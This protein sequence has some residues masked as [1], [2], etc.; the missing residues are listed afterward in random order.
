MRGVEERDLRLGVLALGDVAK[1]HH[2]RGLGAFDPAEVH[3]DGDG[4]TVRPVTPRLERA[5]LF[6]P[7]I[8][9]QQQL[10]RGADQ[11]RASGARELLHT[12]AT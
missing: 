3:I 10:R 7:E 8:L 4:G 5:A 2:H 1:R 6:G 12:A 11:I 9:G